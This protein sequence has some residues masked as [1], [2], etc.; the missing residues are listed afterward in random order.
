MIQGVGE[1]VCGV[2]VYD[3]PRGWRKESKLNERIYQTWSNMIK[4][5]YSKICQEKYPTYI[6]CFVCDKWLKLSG[7]L[8]DI[9]RIEGYELYKNNPNQLIALDKDIKSDGNNKC[10]C[11]EQCSFVRN[12]QN[13]KQA[14]KYKDYEYIKN[15]DKSYCSTKV[16]QYDKNKNLIRIYDSTREAERITK[17]NHKL[18]SSC[19]Q[20]REMNCDREEWL[21]THKYN[22]NKTAGGFI[23]KYYKERK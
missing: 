12:E 3:M 17:I 23:W 2:G 22:P 11:L 4:R 14:V 20:Y 9:E 19:C 1:M 6:D 21:K 13:S 15:M 7:F 18:I 16:A 8:E 5:C 10:Y